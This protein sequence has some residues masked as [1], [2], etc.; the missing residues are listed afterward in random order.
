MREE[1][2]A[3]ESWLAQIKNLVE[4]EGDAFLKC[5]QTSKWG[6][7]VSL[8]ASEMCLIARFQVNCRTGV[9]ERKV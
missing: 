9:M 3:P 4:Y 6:V 5:A 7:S 8:L 2:K 1:F